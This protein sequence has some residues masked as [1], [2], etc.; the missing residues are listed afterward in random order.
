MLS[1]QILNS[2][3]T[4]NNFITLS[5][6]EFV[7][8]ETIDIFLQFINDQLGI[9]YM[10]DEATYPA[11]TVKFIFNKSNGLTEEVSATFMTG[12]RSIITASLSSTVT[13]AILGGNF[14]VEIDLLNDGTNIKK[15]F[16]ENGLT[17]NISGSC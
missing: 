17:K 3:A 6:L 14:V 12:D 4:L 5:A 13:S 10:V 15:V 11:A 2:Q 16:V 1:G 8:G 7:P 9:R